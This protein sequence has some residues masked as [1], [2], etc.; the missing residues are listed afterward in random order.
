MIRDR[1][2]ASRSRDVSPR[3]GPASGVRRRRP[4]G[5]PPPLPRQIGLSGRIWIVLVLV[6]VAIVAL[7]LAARGVGFGFDRWNASVL[8]GVVSIRAGWLTALGLGISTVFASR[9]LVGA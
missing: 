5:E 6:V 7:A 4:S 9:W 1:S 8:R 2:A 3:Q